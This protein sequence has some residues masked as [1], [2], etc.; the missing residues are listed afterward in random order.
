MMGDGYP[1]RITSMTRQGV[2]AMVTDVMD[3]VMKGGTGIYE[4]ELFINAYNPHRLQ[5][6]SLVWS[7]DLG[8]ARRAANVG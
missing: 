7:P 8:R 3:L 6:Q 5:R 2:S 1:K 4:V